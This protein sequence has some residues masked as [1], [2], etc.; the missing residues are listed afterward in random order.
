MEVRRPER[1]GQGVHHPQTL[2]S[3]EDHLASDVRQG[4]VLFYID[5]HMSIQYQSW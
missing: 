3:S 2:C 4:L 1:E 5:L